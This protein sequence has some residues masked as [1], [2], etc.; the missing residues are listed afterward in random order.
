M[1]RPLSRVILVLA[2][3]T[4]MSGFGIHGQSPPR[5]KL[6]FLTHAALYKHTSLGPA[7]K[8]V[9]EMGKAGGFDV[10]TLEGYKQD[11]TALDL[12]FLT[13]DYLAHYDGLSEEADAYAAEI[14]W[15]EALRASPWFESLGPERRR[16]FSWALESAVLTA[17]RARE[18][19]TRPSGAEQGWRPCCRV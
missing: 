11:T 18:T 14:A 3:V 5:R 15:Y 13:A 1:N 7:E 6:L 12:S 4:G 10:T 16:I 17:Q 9:T 19:A 2:M 8:A